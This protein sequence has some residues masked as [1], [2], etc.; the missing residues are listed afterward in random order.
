MIIDSNNTFTLYFR[1]PT[2]CLGCCMGGEYD[3]IVCDTK[4]RRSLKKC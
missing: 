4:S 1:V 3:D 2:D